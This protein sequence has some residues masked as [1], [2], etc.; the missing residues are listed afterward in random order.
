[1]IFSPSCPLS[2]LIGFPEEIY[3][4]NELNILPKQPVEYQVY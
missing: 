4:A 1:M 2:Q 3:T